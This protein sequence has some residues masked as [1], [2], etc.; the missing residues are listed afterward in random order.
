MASVFDG[1]ESKIIQTVIY[2][3]I[4]ILSMGKLWKLKAL[5]N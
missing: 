5:I 3:I 4:D 2:S 1:F